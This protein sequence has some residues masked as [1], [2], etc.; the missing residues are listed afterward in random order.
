[1]L[2]AATSSAAAL[3]LASCQPSPSPP[4]LPLLLRSLAARQQQQLQQQQQQPPPALAALARRAFAS[5]SLAPR[6][7]QQQAQPQAGAAKKAVDAA[8]D[9]AAAEAEAEAA[10]DSQ[11]FELTEAKMRAITDKIPQRPV[12]IVEGTS[13][14]LLI[15]AA[16]A[17]L[18]FFAYNF[19]TTFL[20]EPAATACFNAAAQRLRADPRIA[21][22]LGADITAYGQESASRAAR[23]A[24]PHVM[25]K[26]AQGVEHC[27]LQFHLRGAGGAVA[28]V[29][30]DMYR[31]GEAA[32]AVGAVAGAGMA[33]GGGAAA[34]GGGGSGGYGGGG[35][36]SGGGG[37]A[38]EYAYLI[39][40]VAT[41][42]GG[43]G[44]ARPQQQRLVIVAPR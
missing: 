26:D 34:T 9:A 22:R 38:W 37:G 6:W 43:P 16:F 10:A 25:Y 41:P 4:P 11:S 39:A 14:T 33:G 20:L 32:G 40:D 36:Y 18:A 2:A 15:A 35:G 42:G 12:G 8:A 17:T 21:V 5:T 29:N 27:R 31:A 28:L 13:Y 24:V 44:G 30:A 19:V 3:P 23:Q 7:A 1:V